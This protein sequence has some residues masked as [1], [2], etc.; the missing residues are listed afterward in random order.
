MPLVPQNLLSSLSFIL[1]CQ[2][3]ME[4]ACP[5]S[6]YH[7]KKEKAKTTRC[8]VMQDVSKDK[9]A[10]DQYLTLGNIL[11][12]QRSNFF[13]KHHFLEKSVVYVHNGLSFLAI[14][15]NKIMLF[16]GKWMRLQIIVLSKVSQPQKAK[17]CMFSLIL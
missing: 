3:H 7:K 2:Q 1:P 6:S 17:Y 16:A 15:K 12:P 10:T 8:K 5:L 13:K 9:Q 4:C 14:K 11:K